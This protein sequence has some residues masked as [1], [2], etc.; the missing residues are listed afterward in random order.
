MHTAMHLILT[1]APDPELDPEDAER[2]VRALRVELTEL[3]VESVKSAPP[4][5]GLIIMALRASAS[6]LTSLITVVRDWL[7][8]RSSRHRI[9]L[10]IDGDT[11]EL[12]RATDD[13]AVVEDYIRRHSVES[14]QDG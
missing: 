14:A 6:V 2:H 5:A 10:T 3:D 12:E 4:R 1:V 8:R 13:E 11:L 9:A 7:D